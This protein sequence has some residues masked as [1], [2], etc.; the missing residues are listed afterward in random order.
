[1]LLS[2][3]GLQSVVNYKLQVIGPSHMSFK[4]MCL[5]LQFQSILLLYLCRSLLFELSQHTFSTLN[6][7]C[8]YI[9]VKEYK[10]GGLGNLNSRTKT[11]LSELSQRIAS[12][13]LSFLI[14]QTGLACPC[15]RKSQTIPLLTRYVNLGLTSPIHFF[16]PHFPQ[17]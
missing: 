11:E 1:M 12:P 8:E 10:A 4:M 17:W 5:T 14:C 2:L 13:C 3:V 6:T 16:E 9:K 15:S 7:L